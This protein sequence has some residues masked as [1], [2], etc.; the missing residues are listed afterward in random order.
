MARPSQLI[1]VFDRRGGRMLSAI[2]IGLTAILGAGAAPLAKPRALDVPPAIAPL[3]E[4]MDVV[5]STERGRRT[6][7]YLLRDEMPGTRTLILLTE[8]LSTFGFHPGEPTKPEPPE[9]EKRLSRTPAAAHQWA[10]TF[11]D[12]VGNEITFSL[13]RQCPHETDGLHSVFVQVKGTYL[14][15][16]R[17]AIPKEQP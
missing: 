2:A 9:V 13:V 4:A 10:G 5:V 17:R 3:P 6:V 11:R 8:K 12:D 1:C 15:Y 16:D 14:A 7:V